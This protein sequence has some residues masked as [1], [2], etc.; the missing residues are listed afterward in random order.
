MA[1]NAKKKNR[2]MKARIRREQ[3]LIFFNCERKFFMI[4]ILKKI[5]KIG[6][7]IDRRNCP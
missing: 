3:C 1:S 4:I 5:K 2:I 7:S 6:E